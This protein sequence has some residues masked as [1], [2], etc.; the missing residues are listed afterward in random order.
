VHLRDDLVEGS[1]ILDPFAIDL[2]DLWGD[3]PAKSLALFLPGQLEVGPMAFGSVFMATAVWVATSHP[4]FGN[5]PGT[6]EA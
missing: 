2:S 3:E 4:A 5:A 6:D 1:A